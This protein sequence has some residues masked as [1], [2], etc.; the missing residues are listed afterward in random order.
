MHL[1]VRS[2]VT[3]RGRVL[4]VGGGRRQTYLDF[5]SVTEPNE[6]VVVDIQ[7]TPAVDVV[8]SVTSMPLQSESVDTVLCFNLLE[9]VFD[10]DAA[11]REVRRVMKP[12]AVLYGWVPFIF[13]VH[14]APH[15]Y[16]RYTGAA[17][18]ELLSKAGLTPMKIENSGGV[19]LSAF[20]LLRPYVRLWF[21][22]RILRVAGL[23]LALF[24]GWLF[25][26]IKPES[27]APANCPLGI[28]FV[29]ERQSQ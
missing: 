18:R 11:L 26:R 8:G 14:G 9:H 5:V 23:S 20:D 12:G 2:D 4:D 16:F 28:W 21:A 24:A 15:D 22:G 25:S 19:F 7:P 27:T 1:K 10:H 13:G 6:I 17:L 3:I 29:A